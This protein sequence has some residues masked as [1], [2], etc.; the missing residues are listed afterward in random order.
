MGIRRQNRIDTVEILSENREEP[1]LT[2]HYRG[3]IFRIKLRNILYIENSKRG[4]R[5]VVRPDCEEARFEGKLLVDRKPEVLSKELEMYGFVCSQKSCLI[6]MNHIKAVH[7]DDFVLD[8]GE[9]LRIAR[10][11]QKEF[12]VKYAHYLADKYI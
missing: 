8:T 7:V 11:Y 1:F 10:S 3:N 6:N 12:K 5:V 9:V 4:G 2:A